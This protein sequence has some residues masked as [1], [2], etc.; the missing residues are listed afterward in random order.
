MAVKRKM[1][2]DEI[3]SKFRQFNRNGGDSM[4]P[5]T[6]Y[7]VYTQSNFKTQYSEESRTYK[8]DSRSNL[9]H[10]GLISTS[11]FGDC[12]DGTEYGVR[13]DWYNWKRE[14]CY[15]LVPDEVEFK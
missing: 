11:L 10:D 6:A 7:I 5:L 8:I 1:S 3:I 4:P 13:L 12:L 2:W 15:M 9:F 14:Y